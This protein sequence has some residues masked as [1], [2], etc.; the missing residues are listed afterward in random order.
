MKTI[1]IIIPTYNEKNNIQKLIYELSSVFID[2]DYKIHVIVIDDNS[3]D[4]T[5][6][7][8]R[9]IPQND[10][11]VSL[12]TRKEKLGLGSAYLEGYKWCIDNNF[13]YILQM[14][15]DLSHPPSTAP[16]LVLSIENG[17]D[18][19]IASRYVKHGGVSSWPIHRRFISFFANLL[20][21]IFLRTNI[22]DNT[23]GFRAFNHKTIKL[24]VEYN[25]Q[26]KGFSYL[27]ESMYLFHLK[28]LRIQEIPFIFQERNTGQTK[29][30]YFEIIR[31]LLSIFR[32]LFT[33]L[34][35]T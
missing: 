14:D 31:F 35:K 34:K 8:V 16:T 12:I 33:G 7:V 23:T 21:K 6:N 1:A 13:Q 2:T 11:S 27:I 9:N 18:V 32:I 30:S 19:A 22:N 25:I 20:V 5:A 17:Y 4:G 24:L 10:F 15:A 28:N 26:S 3:P 29:L